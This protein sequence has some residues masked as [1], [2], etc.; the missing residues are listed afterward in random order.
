[1]DICIMGHL[2]PLISGNINMGAFQAPFS[3]IIT[4][5]GIYN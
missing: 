1:M 3:C 5:N 2:E 4:G